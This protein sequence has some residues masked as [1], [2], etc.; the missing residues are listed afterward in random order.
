MNGISM[1]GFKIPFTALVCSRYST[2]E[3]I[4]KE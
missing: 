3:M 4:Q 1:S 2:D